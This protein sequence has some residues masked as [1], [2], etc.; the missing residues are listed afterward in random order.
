MAEAWNNRKADG[1][2]CPW[3]QQGFE[4]KR[5]ILSQH[6]LPRGQKWSLETSYFKAR[7]NNNGATIFALPLLHRCSLSCSCL[8]QEIAEVEVR[9]SVSFCKPSMKPSWQTS[10]RTVSAQGLKPWA[11]MFIVLDRFM[12]EEWVLAISR[13]WLDVMKY[14]HIVIY[15]N[16][17]EHEYPMKHIFTYHYGT[18]FTNSSKR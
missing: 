2:T 8:V 12:F 13:I 15:Q 3:S 9:E 5:N 6:E 4:R 7:Q 10:T 1:L 18:L 16:Q 14:P 11:Y 17:P